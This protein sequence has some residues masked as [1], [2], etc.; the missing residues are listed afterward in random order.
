[1]SNKIVF[2]LATYKNAVAGLHLQTVTYGESA[3]SAEATDEDGYIEQIDV[4]GKKRTIQCE[5]NVTVDANLSALTVGGSLTV[6]GKTYQIDSV[7][8]REAVN[9]HKTASISG[10]APMEKPADAGG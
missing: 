1:M 9:G 2:G 10:S 8:I 5:G 3:S 7:S 6:D 4:Y